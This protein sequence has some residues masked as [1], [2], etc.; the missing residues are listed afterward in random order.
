MLTP[1]TSTA[2]APG[3]PLAQS[4]FATIAVDRPPAN[5]SALDLLRDAAPVTLSM[6]AGVGPARTGDAV[7]PDPVAL[8]PGSGA[9]SR[10]R[11]FLD[12][13]CLG[14][15]L[16]TFGA[17]VVAAFVSPT[18]GCQICGY[19]WLAGG[20]LGLALATQ[21][22]IRGPQDQR[23][24]MDEP[25]SVSIPGAATE[26]SLGL[27]LVGLGG[28]VTW[29]IYAGAIGTGACGLVTAIAKCSED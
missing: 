21:D 24:L 1:S 2:A 10:Y 20:G 7:Q 26:A 8:P 19:G 15:P 16:A 23:M 6:A 11:E 17:G 14:T 3:G 29:P 4:D 22:A 28:P 13:I 12:K 18:L 25:P 9:T 27:F 5:G